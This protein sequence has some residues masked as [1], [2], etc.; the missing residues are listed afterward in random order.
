MIHGFYFR[1]Y[2]YIHSQWACI[3]LSYMAYAVFF[4]RY[5]TERLFCKK[6]YV[7]Y[8]RQ[9]AFDYV[10]SL[11]A[12]P[13]TDFH[14]VR[15]VLIPEIDVSIIVP[16]YNH[17][18]MIE[19][20]IDTILTQETQYR[21]QLILVDDG[22]TDGA[23]E[24]IKKYIN[25]QDI[26]VIFQ[27][28]Q[29]I[30]GARNTGLANA[31]GKYIM[32]VDCDDTV[33]NTLVQTLMDAAYSSDCDI[34]MC[35]HNLVKVRNGKTYSVIPNVYPDCDM[36]GYPED[37]LVL[38]Y[39]GLPWCKVYKRELWDHVSY[40]PGYWFEDTVIHCLL[41]TQCTEFKYI[42]KVCYQYLWYEDNFSHTQG[43]GNRIKNIDIYWMLCDILK[44]YKSME[45]PK[46]SK[47]E[48]V[49]LKHLSAYYYPKIS[50]MDSEVI[51]ALFVLAC[52]L[53]QQYGSPEIKVPYMLRVTRKALMENDI[54][55][56]KLSLKYQK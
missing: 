9:K 22:S 39:A 54:N 5:L 12:K 30:G 17:A 53:Y 6:R 41:F 38:N 13:E 34:A 15:D 27:E 3:L 35:A 43:N 33:D 46:N 16:V 7:K 18:N 32:F 31:N 55:L 2:K 25:R 8:G 47:Y 20:N 24:I 50:G 48:I 1:F 42:S 26:K 36:M 56:W 29:G 4:C 45:L 11:Y 28:N 52:D 21:Y 44:H 23:Q 10:S 37:A 40:L 14:L 51:D 49:L 19:K